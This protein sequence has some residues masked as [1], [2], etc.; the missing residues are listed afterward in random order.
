MIEHVESATVQ[1][2]RRRFTVAEYHQMA[3][4]NILTEEDRVELIDGE[5]RQMS[6]IDPVHAAGVKRLNQL[7][8]SRLANRFIISVQDPI[9][10][11]DLNEPEPDLAILRWHDDFY[12]QQH[13]T[14]G[15]VL[16]LIE[17]A[18]TSLVYDRTEKLPRY[19]AAGIAEVWLVNVAR[20]TIEQYAHPVAGQYQVKKVLSRGMMLEAA[21]I[22]D[23]ALT[24]NQIFGI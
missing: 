12:E 18:N 19:A 16:V 10:L 4:A 7:L 24:V 8:M 13:P 20:R 23:L 9:R 1:V 3:D 5:I 2:E 15:D 6:P 11:D 14:P 22:P 17:V 21:A